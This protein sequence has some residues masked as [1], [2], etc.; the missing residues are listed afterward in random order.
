MESKQ[1]KLKKL[2]A[3]L[4]MILGSVLNVSMEEIQLAEVRVDD[5]KKALEVKAKMER[6]ANGKAQEINVILDE[7]YALLNGNDTDPL[8]DNIIMVLVN[9]RDYYVDKAS[10]AHV[11]RESNRLRDAQRH[12]TILQMKRRL[13]DAIAKR[14]NR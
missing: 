9:E 14:S 12:L 2:G 1:Q 13:S 11:E 5:L 4:D 6:N 10:R 3:S 8:I 7:M